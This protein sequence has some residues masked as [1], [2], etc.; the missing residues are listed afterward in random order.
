VRGILYYISL[1]LDNGHQYMSSS[2]IT[3]KT[4]QSNQPIRLYI[5]TVTGEMLSSSMPI[6]KIVYIIEIY[7]EYFCQLWSCCRFVAVPS[8]FMLL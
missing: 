7:I 2:I 5:V 3:V 6:A 8:D 4:T 1:Q